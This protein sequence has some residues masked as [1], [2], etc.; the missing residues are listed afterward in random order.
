MEQPLAAPLSLLDRRAGYVSRG[1]GSDAEALCRAPADQAARR[2]GAA[3]PAGDGRHRAACVAWRPPPARTYVRVIMAAGIPGSAAG[4]SMRC[5][6]SSWG[7]VSR[8][9]QSG[10][11]PPDRRS[12]SL[13]PCSGGVRRRQDGSGALMA[14]PVPGARAT[15]RCRRP[16]RRFTWNTCPGAARFQF[17][18]ARST[19]DR[20]PGEPTA[21]CTRRSPQGVEESCVQPGGRHRGARRTR[22]GQADGLARR[23]RHPTARIAR[24]SRRMRPPARLLL[25]SRGTLRARSRGSPQSPCDLGQPHGPWPACCSAVET[26]ERTRLRAG[27]GPEVRVWREA[28]PPAGAGMPQRGPWPSA[29]PRRS[30]QC[31]AAP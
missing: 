13:R 28:R 22:F 31:S 9:T 7:R 3:A 23:R 16:R 27:I 19:S 1:A 14:S 2:A 12:H 10:T 17:R 4:S 8:G 26:I 11:A 15:P 18:P 24:R 5:T 29:R 25:R 30:P 21:P 6:R 20:C